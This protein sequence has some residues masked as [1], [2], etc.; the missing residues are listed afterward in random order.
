MDVF[1]GLL[2]TDGGFRKGELHNLLASIDCNPAEVDVVICEDLAT[3]WEEVR[4]KLTALDAP[5]SYPIITT[6]TART[7]ALTATRAGWWNARLGNTLCF[8]G[9]AY[10]FVQG[11]FELL[12]VFLK[13]HR[14][15]PYVLRSF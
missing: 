4:A 2:V 9:D 11:A 15:K 13:Q 3:K 1:G 10:L 6:K 14:D 5:S 8:M 12:I 7:S